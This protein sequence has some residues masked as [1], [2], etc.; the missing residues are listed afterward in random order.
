MVEDLNSQDERQRPVQPLL[1]EGAGGEPFQKR[2]PCKDLPITEN[3]VL[4]N[5]FPDQVSDFTLFLFFT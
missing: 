5:G 3:A 1:E 2:P 4:R